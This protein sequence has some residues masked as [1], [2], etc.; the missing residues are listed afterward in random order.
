MLTWQ[1]VKVTVT[2]SNMSH[3]SMVQFCN[4]NINPFDITE[5]E[6]NEDIIAVKTGELMD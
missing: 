3:D 4:R 6:P 1:P 2:S 5:N